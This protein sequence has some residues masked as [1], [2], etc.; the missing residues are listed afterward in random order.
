M[1]LSIFCLCITLA[2][3][4]LVSKATAGPHL[5]LRLPSINFGKAAEAVAYPVTKSVVNGAKTTLKVAGVADGLGV[6][7]NIGP[8]A[9][10]RVVKKALWGGGR[11]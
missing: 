10:S 2:A 8:P 7:P 11:R 6:V 4:S 9:V 5:R 1:R 3:V